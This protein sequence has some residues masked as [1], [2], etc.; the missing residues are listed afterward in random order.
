MGNP[1]YFT[2]RSR[3]KSIAY[4]IQGVFTFF[5]TQTNAWIHL[6][7][8]IVAIVLGF[9]FNINK[10]EWLAIVFAIALVVVAE[11]LNTALEFLTDLVSPSIHPL[12]KKAKDVGA[13]AVL[14]AAI[15]SLIIAMLVFLPK[16]ICS[17]SCHP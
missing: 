8:A 16:L 11:M 12:A 5:K 10:S 2:F 7:A 9:R 1:K 14:I 4:A 17:Y 15:T 13:G 3:I 6:V